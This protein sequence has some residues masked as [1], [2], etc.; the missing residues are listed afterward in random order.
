MGVGVASRLNRYQLL[1]AAEVAHNLPDLRKVERLVVGGVAVQNLPALAQA[2]VKMQSAKPGRLAQ[3]VDGRA[4]WVADRLERHAAHRATPRVEG[5]RPKMRQRLGA[6]VD[7]I[8]NSSLGRALDTSHCADAEA[9]EDVLRVEIHLKNGISTAVPAHVED[10][11]RSLLFERLS[12]VAELLQAIPGLPVIGW[13]VPPLAASLSLIGAGI[14]R[15]LGDK[16][17]AR[18]LLKMARKHALLLVS[19]LVPIAGSLL[20]ARVAAKDAADIRRLTQPTPE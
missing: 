15:L 1:A 14:A 20:P 17:T 11:K 19:I 8:E 2:H 6:V 13:V 16:P 5:E 12:L 18:A 4:V 3:L 7:K 9:V 10:V